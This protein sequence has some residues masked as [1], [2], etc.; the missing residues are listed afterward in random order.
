MNL[1]CVCTEYHILVLK[2]KHCLTIWTK[3]VTTKTIIFKGEHLCALKYPTSKYYT[4]KKSNCVFCN[5]DGNMNLLLNVSL[6]ITSCNMRKI[7]NYFVEVDDFLLRSVV[8]LSVTYKW[9]HFRLHKKVELY[10]LQCVNLKSY[11]QIFV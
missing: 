8:I 3:L 4:E 6:Q 11:V 5:S 2:I 7:N 10:S 9:P 1:P